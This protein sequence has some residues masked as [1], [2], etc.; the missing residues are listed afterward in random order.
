MTVVAVTGERNEMSKVV[1]VSAQSGA[2]E[3][4]RTH[5]R[6]FWVVA[7]GVEAAWLGALAYLLVR[8]AL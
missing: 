7:L 3:R 2:Q 8:F 1:E 4:S 6:L 5:E